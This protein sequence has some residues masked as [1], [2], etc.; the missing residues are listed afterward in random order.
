V[1]LKF[2]ALTLA[3]LAPFCLPSSTES[4]EE[5]RISRFLAGYRLFSQGAHAEA[6]AP[7]R[8]TLDKDFLLADYSL[9]FLGLASLKQGDSGAAENYFNRLTMDF[10][11]SVWV[12]R[13]LLEIARIALTQGD[14]QRSLDQLRAA[15]ARDDVGEITAEGLWLEAEIDAA[16]NAPDRAY[17]AY[18]ELRRRFPT[19]PWTVDARNKMREIRKSHPLVLG[20]EPLEALLREGDLLV[21]ERVWEEAEVFYREILA[22]WPADKSRARPL[23]AL[24][25]VYEAARWR[26]RA[27]PV[28]E[29][30]TRDYPGSPEAP[31][32]LSRAAHIAWNQNENAAALERFGRL[33]ERYPKSPFADFAQLARARIHESLGQPDVARRLYEELPAKYPTSRHRAEAAWRLAWLHYLRGDYEKALAAFQKTAEIEPQ[34]RYGPAT[35]YWHART[36]EKLGRRE[37]ALRLFAEL[38]RSEDDDYYA[39]A[40]AQ[41]L[42]KLGA[43]PKSRENASN[44]VQPAAEPVVNPEAAP[45]MTRADALA[46]ISL[47]DLAVRELDHARRK[48]NGIGPTLLLIR[49]Y[50]RNR[51]YHR[52]VSL[53]AQLRFKSADLVR[54]RYP[55]AY[56][57]TVEKLAWGKGVDPY[58]VLALTRQESLFDPRAL[59]SASAYGLMQ[60]LPATATMT[61]KETGLPP[62]STDA[63]YEP[64]VNLALGTE[65]LR[66]LLDL[67]DGNLVKALAAYNAGRAV[68]ERWSKAFAGLED[69]EFI[70]RITYAET[71]RYVQLVLRNYRIYSELY[72][73]GR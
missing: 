25:R 26:S 66:Q 20:T 47:H 67:Y 50:G 58:L 36:H 65:H 31:E 39:T 13:A 71:R 40:A 73:Q 29:E 63:L 3:L 4:S 52:S 34:R 24:A 49:E 2:A 62:P 32:A 44:P 56:W 43:P 14:Y 69:D 12:S 38:L 35:R 6:V 30:I 54:H 37:E 16:T 55:L 64:D 9:Y 42:E 8:E 19:S 72:E 17:A 22:R 10:P 5:K 45:H 57:E 60:L 1:I 48:L 15:R 33:Q 28:L 27:L 53:A 41:R 11:S 23:S 61:A 68:V 7:F 51:A 21:R 46:K 18:A 70:E 59:S